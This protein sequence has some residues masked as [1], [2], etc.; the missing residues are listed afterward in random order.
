MG[1]IKRSALFSFGGASYVGLELLWRGRSHGSMFL[2]GGVCF[3]LLG[4]INRRMEGTPP[5]LRGIAGAGVITAVELAAGLLVNRDFHVWD[6]RQLPLNLLGQVCLP[7]SLLWVP[8][9]IGAMA[10]YKALEPRFS[11]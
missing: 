9:S 11:P 8:V 5:I 1:I 2:A 3:V 4:E 7:F 6:Y 10:L